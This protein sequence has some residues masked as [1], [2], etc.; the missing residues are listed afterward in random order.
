MV[1]SSVEELLMPNF[2]GQSTNWKVREFDAGV[3]IPN[4]FSIGSDAAF[5]S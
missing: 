4:E 3:G 5:R 2:S 1:R